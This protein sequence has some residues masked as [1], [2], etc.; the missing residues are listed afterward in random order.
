M[1]EV[2]VR[3]WCVELKCTYFISARAGH[4]DGG[5]GRT[6]IAGRRDRGVTIILSHT[7]RREGGERLANYPTPFVGR[8]TVHP[9]S[10]PSTQLSPVG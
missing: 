2:R 7:R 10:Q 3:V 1:G 9:G 6:G 4:A 5:K 8:S